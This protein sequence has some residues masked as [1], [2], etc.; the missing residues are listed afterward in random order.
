[1]KISCVIARETATVDAEKF[2]E[3]GPLYGS[4]TTWKECK[5]DNV[6]CTDLTKAYELMS[7]AFHAVCNF[8]IPKKFVVECGTLPR[9]HNFDYF[10]DA[11]NSDDLSAMV[12]AATHESNIILLIGFDFA[13]KDKHIFD[14]IT[15]YNDIQWVGVSSEP[16]KVSKAYAKLDN[17]TFDTIDTVLQFADVEKE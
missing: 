5:T 12:V 10:V 13:K 9:V 16:D 11:V 17:L 14:L 15:K 4:W 8:W 3:L 1:M 7:K 2:K 6:V